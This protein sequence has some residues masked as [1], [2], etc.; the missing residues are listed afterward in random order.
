MQPAP[1]AAPA[2]AD[3]RARVSEGGERCGHGDGSP[4]HQRAPP[5][6]LAPHA[7]DPLAINAARLANSREDNPLAQ[8]LLHRPLFHH[9]GPNLKL[10]PARTMLSLNAAEMF[11]VTVV[12]AVL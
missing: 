2:P 4:Q 3:R 9:Q 8:S 11:G 5:L 6:R 12:P 1:A 7:I 10:M